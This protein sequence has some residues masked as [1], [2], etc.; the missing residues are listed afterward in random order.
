[1][2]DARP[3]SPTAHPARIDGLTVLRGVAIGLVVLRH[4][5]PD[6]FGGA[7]IVGVTIFFA[8]S[9]WL[10]S[11][12]LLGEVERTGR[13]DFRRFYLN[14]VFR[15]YPALIAFVVVLALVGVLADPL[16]QGP[17]WRYAVPVA[18]TY[19]AD[20]PLGVWVGSASTHLWTLSVE[21]QFY[22][23]WPLLIVLALRGRHLRRTLGIAVLLCWLAAVL[24]VVVVGHDTVAAYSLPT[25]WFVALAIGGFAR[26][27][28]RDRLTALLGGRPAL[29][30]AVVVLALLCVG[31][32]LKG[33]PLTYLLGGPVIAVA[34]VVLVLAALRV[35]TVRVDTVR[36]VPGRLLLG[37]GTISYAVYLWNYAIVVWAEAVFADRPTLLV[38]VGAT[39]VS[40]GVA[41]AS[42]FLLERPVVR[43][44]RRHHARSSARALDLSRSASGVPSA[45]P[46]P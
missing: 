26:A 34:A 33:N 45:A 30:G 22:L 35:D 5:A 16:E 11:G 39:A 42:W 25:S 43:A 2:S 38:T 17:T 12:I 24:T 44:R 19:V 37:L 36:G 6:V 31:P 1:M 15:L 20:L 10:I 21:E 9:G 23:V 41:T 4:A 14:R 28:G 46:R 3:P 29:A 40:L 8:L 27:L 32:E 13:V 7:G 18:L